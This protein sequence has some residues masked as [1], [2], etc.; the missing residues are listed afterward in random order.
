MFSKGNSFRCRY[1][2]VDKG[3]RKHS[4]LDN[5]SIVKFGARYF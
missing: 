1:G 3:V 2:Y 4:K 5:R